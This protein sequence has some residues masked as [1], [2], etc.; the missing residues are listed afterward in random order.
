MPRQVPSS[1]WNSGACMTAESCFD[2]IVSIAEIAS[3]MLT[4]M[5]LFQETVPLS[6]SSASAAISS[7]AREGSVCLVAWIA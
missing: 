6:A 5:F 2:I 1:F 3:V 4:V 7:S